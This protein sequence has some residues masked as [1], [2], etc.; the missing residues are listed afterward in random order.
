MPV[1]TS[2]AAAMGPGVE[3]AVLPHHKWVA[4]AL[5]WSIN[6]Q[7][8]AMGKSSAYTL[9]DKAVNILDAFQQQVYIKIA[10]SLDID[11]DDVKMPMPLKNQQV[12]GSHR[13]AT[14]GCTSTDYAADN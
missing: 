9:V 1:L 4:K 7:P 14:D 3:V 2:A 5:P 6:V 8:S 13:N 11:A 10:E 12:K